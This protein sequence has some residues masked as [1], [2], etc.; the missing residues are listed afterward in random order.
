MNCVQDI[1][2]IAGLCC[3]Y[4]L[5]YLTY[6]HFKIIHNNIS[7]FLHYRDN[8][9][10]VITSAMPN[11]TRKYPLPPPKSDDNLDD[12]DDDDDRDE[13]EIT[14]PPSPSP[15]P[16]TPTYSSTSDIFRST[17]NTVTETDKVL[18]TWRTADKVLPTQRTAEKQSTKIPEQKTT[19][20][21]ELVSPTPI[22]LPVPEKFIPCK[23]YSYFHYY[24]I[25]VSYGRSRQ[26]RKKRMKM[27]KYLMQTYQR[28]TCLQILQ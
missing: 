11:T 17:Q 25:C 2:L 20:Q 9:Q 24:S 14:T 13:D 16:A 21:S 15:S 27:T 5:L 12:D 18:P 3:K 10:E 6:C 22:Q 4:I 19:P 7:V 26:N 28:N 23:S 1:S 8:S